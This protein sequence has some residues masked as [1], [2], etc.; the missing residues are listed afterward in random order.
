[1]LDLEFFH[2]RRT[3]L[4]YVIVHTYCIYAKR[5]YNVEVQVSMHNID[6]RKGFDSW[7]DYIEFIERENETRIRMQIEKVMR[8]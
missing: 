6:N 5:Q 4:L 2:A 7:R 8:E 1:M 3:S